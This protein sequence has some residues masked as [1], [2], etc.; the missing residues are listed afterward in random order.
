MLAW[1]AGHSCPSVLPSAAW[2]QGCSARPKAQLFH[3]RARCAKLDPTPQVRSRRWCPIP[4]I[5]SRP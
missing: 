3:C 1:A 4:A 2:P 5:S